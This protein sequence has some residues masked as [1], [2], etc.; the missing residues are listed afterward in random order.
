MQPE[1]YIRRSVFGPRRAF[2][3]GSG[4]GLPRA[5]AD[6]RSR[7]VPVWNSRN[8]IA[9]G[10]SPRAVYARAVAHA[11]REAQRYRSGLSGPIRR[12]EF[13]CLRNRIA[14]RAAIGAGGRRFEDL[15]A[16]GLA[17]ADRRGRTCWAT[18]APWSPGGGGTASAAVAAQDTLPP[19]AATCW[20]APIPPAATNSFRA[21]IRPSSCWSATAN[22][23][24]WGARPA[25]PSA[26][27]PPSP[28]SSNR[29]SR[30]RMR[31]RARCSRKPASKSIRSNTTP[32]SPGPFRRR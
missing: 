22:A 6:E 8:L 31:W 13:L 25:G 30:S 5:L 16:R 23:R 29:E 3:A 4:S 18:R 24:C 7:V 26:A 2:A 32:P 14:G 9:E 1:E 27:T 12:H 19:R 15:R 17:A 11:A 21:S 20:S 28:A 10:E